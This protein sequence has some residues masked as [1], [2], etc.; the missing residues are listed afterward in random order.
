ML[1]PDVSFARHVLWKERAVRL[2]Q[3]V[4]SQQYLRRKAVA[5]GA[6]GIVL[7][8][9]HERIELRIAPQEGNFLPDMR[10]HLVDGDEV[11]VGVDHGLT[12]GRMMEEVNYPAR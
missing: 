6:P 8:L 4:G 12:G 9:I 3:P 10:E 5:I 2:R 1:G 11:F 7:K